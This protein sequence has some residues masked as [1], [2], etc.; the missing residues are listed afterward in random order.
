MGLFLSAHLIYFF[1][2]SEFFF[3]K[4]QIEISCEMPNR[5]DDDDFPSFPSSLLP[6]PPPPFRPFTRRSI[7]LSSF[8]FAEGGEESA[9]KEKDYMKIIG[10]DFVESHTCLGI[11]F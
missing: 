5:F 11:P 10:T 8:V 9:R 2:R 1:H 3:K 7:R 6:P 4:S